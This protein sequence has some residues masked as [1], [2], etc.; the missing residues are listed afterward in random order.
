VKIAHIFYSLE[1]GGV[2]TL[3]VNIANWQVLNGYNVTI[4]LIN[5]LYDKNLIKELNEKINIIKLKRSLKSKNPKAIIKLN[6]YLFVNG[7]D[8][9]HIHSAGIGNIILPIFKAKRVLHV[10]STTYITNTKIPKFDKCI[11]IS[12]SV[13]KSLRVEYNINDVE[14][15]YNGVNFNRIKKKTSLNISNKIINI[16]RLDI[17][18]KNQ[19]GLIK[20]FAAIINQID[21]N[22]YIVG[23]GYDKNILLSLIKQLKLEKRVFLLGQKS[24]SWIQKHLSEYDLLIQA[25]HSEG[26]GISAIEASAA[27]VPLLLSNVD[28]HIEISGNEKLCKLFD[29]NQFGKLGEGILEFYVNPK[30]NFINALSSYKTQKNRFDFDLCNKKLNVI[31]Q[32]L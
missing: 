24:Q 9:L 28:G 2:E 20:E 18:I 30:Q 13:K 4:I 6:Y 19:N 32:S 11:A 23:D 10:H 12:N 14:V 5:N 27:C 7:Y 17:S 29:V 8:I 25:S 22:L 1:M 21:A 15:I 31:Y 16:G 26:L 3:L